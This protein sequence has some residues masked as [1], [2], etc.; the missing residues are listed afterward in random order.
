MTRVETELAS[1]EHA[2]SAT[3]KTMPEKQCAVVR[4]AWMRG[5]CHGAGMATE[6][7]HAN[8]EALHGIAAAYRL[9]VIAMPD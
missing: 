4:V 1:F 9:N 6:A 7:A 3:L 2:N 8:E 5:A